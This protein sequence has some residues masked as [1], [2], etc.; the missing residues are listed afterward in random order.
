MT[1]WAHS[2][3]QLK[4]YTLYNMKH[5]VHVQGE[6][7]VDSAGFNWNPSFVNVLKSKSED[8]PLGAHIMYMYQITHF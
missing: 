5:S 8:S 4:T 2:A 6:L 3:R 7:L 1:R